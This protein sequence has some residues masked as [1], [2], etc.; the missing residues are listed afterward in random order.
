[1]RGD[2]DASFSENLVR[3]RSR[4]LTLRS[5]HGDLSQEFKFYDELTIFRNASGAFQGKQSGDRQV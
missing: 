2:L 1:M 5:G 3:W 4:F